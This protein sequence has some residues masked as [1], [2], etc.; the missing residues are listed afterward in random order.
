MIRDES[1]NF[2]ASQDATR[3]YIT[4]SETQQQVSYTG[5]SKYKVQRLTAHNALLR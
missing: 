2:T 3:G 4:V 5:T 1:D